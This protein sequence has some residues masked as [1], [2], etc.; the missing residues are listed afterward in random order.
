MSAPRASF[1]AAAALLMARDLRLALRRA[2]A[3]AAIETRRGI[4]YSLQ[5]T[6]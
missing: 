6:P 1:A 5:K 4:G 2:G 3:K